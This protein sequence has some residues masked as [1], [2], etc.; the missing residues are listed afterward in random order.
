[1]KNEMRKQLD[2]I[3]MLNEGEVA[4]SVVTKPTTSQNEMKLG[5]NFFNKGQYL[6]AYRQYKMAQQ[7]EP[8]YFWAYFN[9]ASSAFNARTPQSLKLIPGEINKSNTILQ[10][11]AGDD[12]EKSA[13]SYRL[14][15]LLRSI[16]NTTNINI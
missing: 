3:R 16:R 12:K 11:W 5:D 2:N 7:K 9:A 1:M 6:D 13:A 14:Q 15:T 4:K 8:N 10:N